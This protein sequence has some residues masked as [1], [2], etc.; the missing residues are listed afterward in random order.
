MANACETAGIVFVTISD[1]VTV[2]LNIV[3]VTKVE[4]SVVIVD[5]AWTVEG[6][7]A[8][9]AVVTVVDCTAITVLVDGVMKRQE[10][11][12]ETAGA[13]L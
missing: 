9:A 8:I 7:V 3:V 13:T 10:Q 2:V 5:V 11:A 12:L 6:T 4:V 1:E